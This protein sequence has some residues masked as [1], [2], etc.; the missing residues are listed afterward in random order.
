[1]VDLRGI[2]VYALSVGR[3][4]P[5]AH[6]DYCTTR[7]ARHVDGLGKLPRSVCCSNG[8]CTALAKT[9]FYYRQ[10]ISALSF[11]RK[12]RESSTSL[13]SNIRGR[14]RGCA[15]HLLSHSRVFS[16]HS[17]LFR[18]RPHNV[19]SNHRSCPVSIRSKKYL[20]HKI[21]NGYPS[22]RTLSHRNMRNSL[23]S[24]CSK[25]WRRCVSFFL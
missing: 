17:N 6:W 12:E 14:T 10:S 3:A 18:I 15:P 8:I 20:R 21:E 1:M 23:F 9:R 7:N 13:S 24:L 22:F 11:S 19:Y 5:T 4:R 16:G 2:A 25:Q